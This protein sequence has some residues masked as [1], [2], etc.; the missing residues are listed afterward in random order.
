MMLDNK[1]LI[2]AIVLSIAILLGFQFL[3]GVPSREESREEQMS[4]TENE[5]N[6]S[7]AEKS[8]SLSP[9]SLEDNTKT[10]LSI[11]SIEKKIITKE[12][13]LLQSPR[14]QIKTNKVNGSINLQGAFF[15]DLTLLNYTKTLNKN[16][17]KIYLLSPKKT[18]NPYYAAFGWVSR[19]KKIVLPDDKTI[20]TSDYKLLTPD[21]P[22][23]LTWN[24]ANGL[25]FKKYI[26]IDKN[27]MFRITHK[28][29]NQTKKDIN[30]VPY[31]YV[32]RDGAPETQGFFIL[33]EGAIGVYD[34]VLKQPK[35]KH[36]LKR[37]ECKKIKG[38]RDVDCTNK[39]LR[40]NND[41][42]NETFPVK[43]WIGF[44]DKYW[45]TAL[46]PDQKVKSKFRYRYQ[47]STKTCLGEDPNFIN[48]VPTTQKGPCGL[49]AIQYERSEINIG[50]NET[51][52]YTDNFFAG[53]KV[54][55]LLDNYGKKL[56]AT[57]F[58]RAVDFGILFFLTKPIFLGLRLIYENLGNFGISII[59]LTV[60]IKLIF[61]P[62]A[63]RSYK[64]MAKMKIVAP[65]MKKIRERYKNDRQKQQQEIM[66][67]YKKEGAN[68]IS[69]CLPLVIQIPV[70]FALYK[71]LFVTIEMR[72]APFFGWI[73]DLS[74]PDPLNLFTLFGIIPW[75]TPTF[76]PIIGI[77]PLLMGVSMWLQMRLNP[78]PMDPMQARIFMLMPIFFTF[79]LASFPAGLVIYWT[80]NNVLSIAQ[81]WVIMKKTGVT[82]PASKE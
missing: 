44:T 26:E 7:R 50:S 22:V 30:L 67:L 56:N 43:G 25:I 13:A 2:A 8:D 77:W 72:H 15:D 51:V 42:N 35:Y 39:K 4:R 29:I 81:Q 68:P 78:Q 41:N 59:L 36:I 32:L 3:Y 74:A 62:L 24:N 19:N 55:R 60:L 46:V 17:D 16:S 40:T 76:I 54:V 65:E 12:K 48:I 82:N 80:W 63:N 9:P 53:A 52:S 27:Y 37:Y 47:P 10:K 73:Q 14:I 69:G 61:F 38:N 34:G 58:D 70:F 11:K 28:I 75:T 1:N 45:L 66:A 49:F 79:L 33:H 20:W 64:A 23:T 6:L 71:V 21:Q 57:L 5:E 18:I 31:G